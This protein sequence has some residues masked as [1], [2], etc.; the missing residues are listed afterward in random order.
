MAKNCP[1]CD[2]SVSDVSCGPGEVRLVGSC[3]GCTRINRKVW[4]I[5]LR[6]TE[7][8][9]C[10]QCRREVVNQTKGGL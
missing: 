10:K 9:L 5:Q 2:Q 4:V 6:S 1:T 7:I 8:R 3:N